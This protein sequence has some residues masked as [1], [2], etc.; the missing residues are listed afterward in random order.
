[1]LFHSPRNR[2]NKRRNEIA[3]YGEGLR[4]RLSP[5]SSILTVTVC[6]IIDMFCLCESQWPM[7]KVRGKKMKCEAILQRRKK[8][9]TSQT[10]QFDQLLL[11]IFFS[12]WLHFVSLTFGWVFYVSVCCI[13]AQLLETSMTMMNIER[14]SKSDVK[15]IICLTCFFFFID[16]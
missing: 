1:M 3:M 12:A 8:K 15:K 9:T 13:I 14:K 7:W 4:I 11:H 2:D 5:C 10:K 16:C 6:V